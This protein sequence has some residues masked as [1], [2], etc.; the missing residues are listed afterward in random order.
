MLLPCAKSAP[1]AT[2]MIAPEMT[3]ISVAETI[4]SRRSTASS[5]TPQPF[6]RTRSGRVT[7]VGAAIVVPTNAASMRSE[8]PSTGSVGDSARRTVAASGH[9]TKTEI[10]N[11]S[12]ITKTK[13]TSTFSKKE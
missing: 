12:A 9:V 8:A 10:T 7:N 6:S 11:V 5:R 4:A 1:I 2:A 3:N 13:N